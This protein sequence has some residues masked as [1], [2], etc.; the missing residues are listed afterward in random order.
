MNK[1]LILAAMILIPSLALTG[2]KKE[3]PKA[4]DTATK[5]ADDA[6]AATKKAADDAAKKAADDAAKAA[7]K[8]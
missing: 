5:A 7:E 1:K 6:A 4:A 8:K 2:C 3:E